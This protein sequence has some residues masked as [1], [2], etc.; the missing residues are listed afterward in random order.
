MF[1]PDE[2]ARAVGLQT[3]SYQLLKWVGEAVGKGFISFKTA[4]AY[5]SIPAAATE[6]LEAHYLNLPERAR[7]AREDIPAFSQILSTYLENSFE[8]VEAPGKRVIYPDGRCRCSW[9][10]RLIDAS[11]LK[12]RVPTTADKKRARKM[13]LTELKRLASEHSM[14][15][16]DDAM[17]AIVEAPDIRKSLALCAYGTDLL[18]RV[19]GV[20]TGPAVLVL[21]RTFAWLP[22]GS[23]DKAF[24]LSADLIVNAEI[25]LRDRVLR[26]AMS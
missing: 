25:S 14:L 15:L 5:A 7:P 13:M 1:N 18:H 11:N 12:L 4:H 21:W 24:S 3:R 17:D 16:L 6:W 19:N 26:T 23:A 10:A 20:A 22:T 8:W 9:C 2:I